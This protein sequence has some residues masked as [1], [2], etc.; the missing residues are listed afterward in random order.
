MTAPFNTCSILPMQ[1]LGLDGATPVATDNPLPVALTTGAL[2]LSSVSL[3]TSLPSTTQ[4]L[5]PRATGYLVWRLVVNNTTATT[6]NL[7]DGG[8][9]LT[10]GAIS[11][12]ANGQFNL[13][14]DGLPL[15]SGAANAT[16]TMN[17]S[18]TSTISG[19]LYYT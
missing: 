17:I 8:T 19:R 1:L 16:L 14:Y 5:A 15:F 2:S 9:S 10:G 3:S 4:L 13:P 18:A 12:P 7:L 11:L 6:F